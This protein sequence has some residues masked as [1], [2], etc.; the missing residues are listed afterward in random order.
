[1]I[2]LHRRSPEEI[3]ALVWDQHRPEVV[4]H[5]RQCL[6]GWTTDDERPALAQRAHRWEQVIER[7]RPGMY[8]ECADTLSKALS[9]P[10][11][12]FDCSQ[13]AETP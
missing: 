4:G 1:M 5:P 11:C 8:A 7:L 3:A 13:C 6:C 10:R 12:D 9:V 2:E